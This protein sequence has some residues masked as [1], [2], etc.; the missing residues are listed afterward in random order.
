MGTTQDLT[1]DRV[2]VTEDRTEL[3]LRTRTGQ[4]RVIVLSDDDLTNLHN[5]MTHTP[6]DPMPDYPLAHPFTPDT[7]PG[8]GDLC[9]HPTEED[10][11]DPG[12]RCGWEADDHMPASSTG[13]HQ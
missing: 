3:V 13:A 1:F 5:A 9:Q 4:A 7:R 10:G 8:Y 6:D 12:G 2:R 11:R